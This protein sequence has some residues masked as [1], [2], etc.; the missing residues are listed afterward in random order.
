MKVLRASVLIAFL[1]LV[2]AVYASSEAEIQAEMLLES[3]EMEALMHHS[4]SQMMD[5]QL[6]QNPELLPYKDVMMQF[7]STYMSWN[8]LKPEFIKMYSTEFTAAEL[9]EINK[10]YATDTG[11]KTIEK[12]PTLM[13]Q[14]AQIGMARVQANMGELVAMIK[15]EEERLQM[16][17][18]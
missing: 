12:M 11:K 13:N 9:R 2:P 7:F 10:F 17:A 6:Q 8:S 3:M 15:A 5:L 4:I 18:K 1:G 14:G 16:L